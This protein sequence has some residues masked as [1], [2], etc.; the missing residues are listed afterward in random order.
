MSSQTARGTGSST[1]SGGITI[2]VPD[3]GSVRPSL[4]GLLYR[5]RWIFPTSWVSSGRIRAGMESQHVLVLRPV[6]VTMDVGVSGAILVPECP[7]GFRCV[8]C[9]WSSCVVGVSVV[10][11]LVVVS[12]RTKGGPLTR[13][14]VVG[15]GAVVAHGLWSR[16]PQLS[17]VLTGRSFRCSV[18]SSALMGAESGRGPIIH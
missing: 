13:V 4:S 6:L 18:G 12:A 17:G 7:V 10:G 9:P 1:T 14:G 16:C 11:C 2:A 8:G 3:R 5:V 15:W